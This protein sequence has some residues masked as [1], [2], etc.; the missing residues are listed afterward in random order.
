MTKPLRV[1][2]IGA[3][4]MGKHH[5]RIYSQLKDCELVAVIDKDL[6]RARQ[7]SAQHGGEAF[8][9]VADVK[10]DLDA[11]S[12]A[13]PTVY[14]AEVAIPLIERG[15]A[16]LV[17]KPLAPD[18]VTARQLLDASL[19]HQGLLQVGHSERFNPVV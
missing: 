15:V 8:T 19:S 18:S 6:D 3:G 12:V 16:V 9:R 1:A 4:H 5:A 2:L 10:G 13:V 7:I 17:E 11:V 14:H